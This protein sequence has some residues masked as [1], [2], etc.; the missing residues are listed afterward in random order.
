MKN[1]NYMITQTLLAEYAKELFIWGE[2]HDLKPPQL[3]LVLNQV[4]NTMME[5]MGMTIREVNTYEVP[6]D[7]S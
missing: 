2:Q 6:S 1:D 5:A 7:P 4:S 3:A